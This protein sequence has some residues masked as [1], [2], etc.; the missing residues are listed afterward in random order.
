M[1]TLTGFIAA[2]IA[3][4]AS[5][6][7]AARTSPVPAVPVVPA[8]PPATHSNPLVAPR[9]IDGPSWSIR[10]WQYGR[11]IFEEISVRPFPENTPGLTQMK[12]Q[13]GRDPLQMIDRQNGFCL[14]RRDR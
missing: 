9:A 6:A 12:A 7:D 3:L 1:R 13:D 10:C 14:V 8:A 4:L 11:L 5:A 2:T